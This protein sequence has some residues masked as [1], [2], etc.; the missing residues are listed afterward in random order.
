MTGTRNDVLEL[1]PDE[2]FPA[3]FERVGSCMVKK[4]AS[5]ALYMTSRSL[6]TIALRYENVPWCLSFRDVAVYSKYVRSSP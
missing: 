6:L 1:L 3:F 4:P 2:T 5:D